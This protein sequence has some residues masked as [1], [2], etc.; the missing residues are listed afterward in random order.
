MMAPEFSPTVTARTR[1][2]VDGQWHIQITPDTI[3]GLAADLGRGVE[4][5]P[6]NPWATL[7]V[8]RV[9]YCAWIAS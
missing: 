6:G 1:V 2:K 4:S 7:R 8:D 5:L 9:R 3:Y